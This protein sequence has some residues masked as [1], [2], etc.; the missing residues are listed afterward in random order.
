MLEDGGDT[1]I[2][3]PLMEH[4]VLVGEEGPQPSARRASQ[5]QVSM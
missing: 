4:L 2:V 3:N 1:H 5:L